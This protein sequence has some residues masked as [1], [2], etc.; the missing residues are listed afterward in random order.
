VGAHNSLGV[1]TP[2]ESTI[3]QELTGPQDVHNPHNFNFSYILTGFLL[4]LL[5]FILVCS[6]CFLPKAFCFIKFSF[7]S[8]PFKD[9]LILALVFS[10]CFDF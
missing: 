4:I 2:W 5:F 8:I 10:E 1:M 7:A 9:L 6:E 3:C